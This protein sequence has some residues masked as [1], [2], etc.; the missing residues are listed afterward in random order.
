MR[1]VLLLR[2]SRPRCGAFAFVESSSCVDPIDRQSCQRKVNNHSRLNHVSILM[3]RLLLFFVDAERRVRRRSLFSR[4]LAL[5]PVKQG[6]VLGNGGVL[7]HTHKKMYEIQHE[8]S[9][10]ASL[11]VFGTD[12]AEQLQIDSNGMYDLKFDGR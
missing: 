3:E 2:L 11:S 4:L 10:T 5:G 8:L 7:E 6:Y 9:K 12:L 1:S